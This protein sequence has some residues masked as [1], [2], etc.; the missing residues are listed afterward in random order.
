MGRGRTTSGQIA[1]SLIATTRRP[2]WGHLPAFVDEGILTNDS[3]DGPSEEE[4][5]N[6]GERCI[7]VANNHLLTLS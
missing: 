1:A 6:E 7:Y 4:A 2:D 3:I 5:Y